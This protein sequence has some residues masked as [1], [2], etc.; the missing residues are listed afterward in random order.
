[1]IIDVN[2]RAAEIFGY[3]VEELIGERP[4]NILPPDDNEDGKGK[5]NEVCLAKYYLP[6]NA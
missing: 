2:Q 3:T 5:M 1:M 6:M 4:E